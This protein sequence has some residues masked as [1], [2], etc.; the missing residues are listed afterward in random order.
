MT[1]AGPVSSTP[2]R[3]VHARICSL[4]VLL[5]IERKHIYADDA[6][7][8]FVK[9]HSLSDQDRALAFELVYGVLR[10]QTFLDWRLNMV[11]NRPILRLPLPVSCILRIGAYQ[12][13]CLQAIPDSAAVN[14]AVKLAKPIKGRDWSGFV[15]AVLRALIREPAP[16]LPDLHDHPV[17]ALSLHYSCPSWLVERWIGQFGIQGA[18]RICR[19]TTEIPPLTLRVNTLRCSRDRLAAQLRE[20]GVSVRPT[21]VSQV[22]LVVEKCG[23]LK[24]FRPLKDG[25][26]YVEDEA[27]QLVP[28]LLD[29]QPGDRVLDVCAAPGG[30]TTH[31]AAL[32]E[33]VGEIVAMDSSSNRLARLKENCTRLGVSVVRPF[34]IDVINSTDR[35]LAEITSSSGRCGSNRQ[36]FDRILVDAPC[37]G[38]G[39]LRRHPEGKWIKTGEDLTRHHASQLAILGRVATLLRPGGVLVYSACSGEPEETVQVIKEFCRSHPEFSPESAAPWAPSVTY[40]LLNE[41]GNLLT[42]PTLLSMDGFF[43]ARLRKHEIP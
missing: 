42:M 4:S 41:D 24:E 38:L 40:P 30:K 21:G 23:A 43:A 3:L 29:V 26:C 1:S 20:D 8:Q 32:M 25:F 16:A 22:G 37:S 9:T 6:F 15:N 39:I 17:T 19:S 5:K 34:H 2:N 10:H 12:I 31:L 7:D 36:D 13:L 11:S 33:N 35:S 28:L 18:E 27:A 14:E